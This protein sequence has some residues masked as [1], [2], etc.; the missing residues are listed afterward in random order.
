MGICFSNASINEK[1]YINPNIII[2]EVSNSLCKLIIDNKFIQGFFIMF[3]IHNNFY[4]LL[5]TGHNFENNLAKN[6]EYLVFEYNNGHKKGKIKL[7]NQRYIHDFNDIG[8]SIIEIMKEDNIEKEHFLSYDIDKL[9]NIKNLKDKEILLFDSS[10]EQLSV[11]TGN[12]TQIFDQTFTHTLGKLKDSSGYPILLENSKTVIGINNLSSKD[13]YNGVFI[14]PIYNHIKSYLNSEKYCT[15][16]KSTNDVKIV[17]ISKQKKIELDDGGYYIGELAN[18]N[19]PNGKGKYFFKNGETY[20]GEIKN[21]KF[22]GQ[23]KYKY[24]N[25]EYYIGQW[26][27]DLKQ[28]KGILYYEDENIK[29]DGDFVNDKFEGKGKYYWENGEFYIGDFKNGLNNG[30]GILYYKDKNIKYEGDFINDNF[31]GK[32]NYIYE[33]K[34]YYSGEFKNG[35]K[36]GKGKLYYNDGSIQYEGDFYEGQYHGMGKYIYEEGDYYSGEFK[37]GLCNGKGK[38]YNKNG[39]LINEGEWENDIK[40]K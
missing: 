5:A 28:G 11:L 4:C 23:G 14:M 32:G 27:D 20:E 10:L 6:N 9:N 1:E 18:N 25:G 22:E 24:N 31:E 34:G 15:N 29:Y 17:E 19:I 30:K 40:I 37:N 7:N 21:D 26:K 33:D 12:I 39:Q 13:V 3:N 8:I 38:E 16:H 2:K 36:H 35:L